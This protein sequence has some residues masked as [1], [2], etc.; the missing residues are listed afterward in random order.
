LV[1][2][3]SLPGTFRPKFSEAGL[4]YLVEAQLE[5]DL[6]GKGLST[7]ITIRHLILLR[8]PSSTSS[9]VIN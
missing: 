7:L 3:Y 1:I 5:Y 2:Q 4:G 8:E 6:R 9:L